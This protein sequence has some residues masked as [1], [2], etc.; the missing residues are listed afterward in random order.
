MQEA[1]RAPKPD[2]LGSIGRETFEDWAG[3]LD[4][5]EPQLL[6]YNTFDTVVYGT[7]PIRW[8]IGFCHLP[9]ASCRAL[10]AGQNFSPALLPDRMAD[11]VLQHAG[12]HFSASEQIGLLLHR[13]TPARHTV[14]FGKTIP[15]I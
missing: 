1:S 14:D 4:Q 7:V 15:A 8:E 5:G 9:G 13:I 12:W 11:I 10:L 3:N 6:T 2:V